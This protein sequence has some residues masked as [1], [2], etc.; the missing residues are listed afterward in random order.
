MVKSPARSA[1]LGPRTAARIYLMA[2]RTGGN[3]ISVSGLDTSRFLDG[4]EY[5]VFHDH[6]NQE[7]LFDRV[8]WKVSS[9]DTINMNFGFTPK[10]V[11][12]SEFIRRSERNSVVTCRCA[13]TI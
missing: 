8:D 3:F 5:T 1:A 12:D 7:N 6:G 2:G 11:P 4:P 9:K 10:L 13:K